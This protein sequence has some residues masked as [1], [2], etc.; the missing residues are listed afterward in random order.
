MTTRAREAWLRWLLRSGTGV[1]G[2][3]VGAAFHGILMAG[4]ATPLTALAD[5]RPELAEAVFMATH[6]F[7][8]FF[9]YAGELDRELALEGTDA[10][11]RAA[12]NLLTSKEHQAAR[13]VLLNRRSLLTRGETAAP[14]SEIL[15]LDHAIADVQ[16]AAARAPVGKVDALADAAEQLWSSMPR[17]ARTRAL[18]LFFDTLPLSNTSAWGP[19]FERALGL[20]GLRGKIRKFKPGMTRQAFRDLFGGEMN[21]LKG[22]LL[23]IFFWHSPAWVQR[24]GPLFELATRRAR[25]LSQPGREF[26]PFLINEPLLANG[27]EIFDGII[28]L[29]RASDKPPFLDEVVLDVVIQIKAE[30]VISVMRQ[31]PK[32]LRRESEAIIAGTILRTRSGRRAFTIIPAGDIDDPLRIIVAPQLPTGGRLKT[33]PVGAEIISVATLHDAEQMDDVAR[34]VIEATIR[35]EQAAKATA[36]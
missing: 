33:A 34:F 36:K 6:H 13:R 24:E 30:R 32:D 27:K 25:E 18:D 9:H 17:A 16:R 7:R 22:A 11:I 5:A 2:S 12:S 26:T 10:L 35:L 20:G 21:Q 23:E 4:R 31:I 19:I 28:G 3:V 14:V 15:K 1:S 29:A 8:R